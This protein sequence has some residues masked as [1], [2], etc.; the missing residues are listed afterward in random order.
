MERMIDGY[1]CLLL[2]IYIGY[3][4]DAL[5]SEFIPL[6]LTNSDVQHLKKVADK[7]EKVEIGYLAMPEG[8]SNFDL[9]DDTIYADSDLSFVLENLVA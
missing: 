6:P 2:D 8:E 3:K 7:V 9:C 1:K 5:E 4:D